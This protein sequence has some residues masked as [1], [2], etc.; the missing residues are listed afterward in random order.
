[1]LKFEDV[2][3]MQMYV[4]LLILPSYGFDNINYSV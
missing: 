2:K 3:I 4:G 1:M